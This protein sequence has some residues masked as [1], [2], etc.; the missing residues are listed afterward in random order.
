MRLLAFLAIGVV[1]A[2]DNALAQATTNAPVTAPTNMTPVL[3]EEA[4]EKAWS[5][6]AFAYTY[7]VPD[8]HDYVQPTITA[9]RG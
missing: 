9:D 3:P 4:D 6:S 5:F 1:L 8:S 2:G 7:I